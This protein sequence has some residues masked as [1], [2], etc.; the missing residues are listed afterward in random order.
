[1]E[2]DLL[3]ALF[4]GDLTLALVG[5]L[6]ALAR[7]GPA[8]WIAPFLGGRMVPPVVKIASSLAFAAVL[9]PHLIV[10]VRPL[11]GAPAA[12]LLSLLVKEAAVGAALGF[13]VAL[14]FLAAEA[15]G[16][17]A[18]AMRGAS[19][20]E[21]MVPPLGA[22][23]SPLGDLYFQLSVVLFLSLGG[24]RIFVTALG[25]SY[26]LLPLAFFPRAQGL[27][28]FAQLCLRLTADLLLLA[29]SL[30]APVVAV[31]LLADLTLGMVNRFVPQL[32]VFFLAM[33]ARA[34]L[35]IAVLVLGLGLV[36]GALPQ[37]MDLAVRHVT[38]ALQALGR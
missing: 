27:Q 34:L 15:A 19:L 2:R 3:R 20:A 12:V 7:V 8:L 4:G 30:A 38:D 29:V 33:P 10:A 26:E 18:D 5:G 32:A 14:V 17:L 21:V 13:V 1:M 22:R 16:R 37:A 36:A 11:A 28:S 31:L 35:G 24:H 6:F 23:S 25:A 9:S